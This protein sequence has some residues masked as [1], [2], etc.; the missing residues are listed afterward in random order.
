MFLIDL[1]RTADQLLFGNKIYYTLTY[2]TSLFLY[3]HSCGSL[4]SVK[5]DQIKPGIK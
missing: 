2:F 1:D 3:Q 5:F 4:P